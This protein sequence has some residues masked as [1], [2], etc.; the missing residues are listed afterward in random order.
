M[1]MSQFNWVCQDNIKVDMNRFLPC[2]KHGNKQVPV[3]MRECHFVVQKGIK[4]R[5]VPLPVIRRDGELYYSSR[6][7]QVVD[8]RRRVCS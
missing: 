8:T 1:L 2:S 3:G 4:W 7:Q 5:V 6:L